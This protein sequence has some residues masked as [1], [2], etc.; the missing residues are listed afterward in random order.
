MADG[1]RIDVDVTS[2]QRRFAREL[3]DL[4]ME[5]VVFGM[6]MI[7]GELEEKA[8]KNIAEMFTHEHSTGRPPHLRLE[9]SILG[10][11]TTEGNMVI[12][13]VGYDLEEVPYARMLELGGVIP[14]HLIKPRSAK[15]LVFPTATLR[16]FQAGGETTQ[17][18][19]VVA[20]QVHHPGTTQPGYYYLLSA[21]AEM[22]RTVDNDIE[23]AVARAIMRSGL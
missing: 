18:E 10:T 8:L 12:G 6:R 19:F 1:I 3:P 22:A 7:V 20:F 17:H 23:R 16:E 2:I 9:D 5:E 13:T 14:A 11:V 15:A 4:T 21:L